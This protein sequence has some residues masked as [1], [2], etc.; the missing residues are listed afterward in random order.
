MPTFSKFAANLAR[1]Q[2]DGIKNMGEITRM[3]GIVYPAEG[4]SPAAIHTAQTLQA[5]GITTE[6]A[7]MQTAIEA[8]FDNGG[9]KLSSAM[10]AQGLKWLLKESKKRNTP[11][12]ERETDA[13]QSCGGIVWSN[14][15]AHY[16]QRTGQTMYYVPVFT[17]YD[18]QSEAAFDY[19][20]LNGK[21]EICG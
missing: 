16:S 11:M 7:E 4:N 14:V 18:A 13:V 10:V 8:Y 19:Y 6:T 1:I 5:A 9:V 17:V 15:Y 12:C 2:A 20:V 3:L 21:I